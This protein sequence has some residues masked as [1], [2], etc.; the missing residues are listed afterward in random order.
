M[1]ASDSLPHHTEGFTTHRRGK[2]HVYSSIL[3]DSFTRSKRIPKK[4]K[5]NCRMSSATIN[6]LAV[7]NPCLLRMKFQPALAK[8]LPNL[9]QSQL[10]LR[11][12]FAMNYPIISVATEPHA[13]QMLSNPYVKRIV[14]EKV[15][16]QRAYHSSHTI[17]NLAYLSVV[18]GKV[19]SLAQKTP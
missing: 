9:S 18:M 11:Q 17:D 12:T 13:A 1:P 8:S 3:I 6:V 16:Q 4:R 5:S 2:V 19:A 10:R 15:S 7:N 14:Q